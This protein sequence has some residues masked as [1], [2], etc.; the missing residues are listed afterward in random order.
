[1]AAAGSCPE[2][3]HQPG[4]GEVVEDT[5][6]PYFH[7][8]I[9]LSTGMASGIALT[10]LFPYMSYMVMDLCGGDIN[11]AGYVSGYVAS[12]FMVG[13]LF[14]SFYW[15]GVADQIGRKPVFYIASISVAIMSLLFGLSVNI[16]MAIVARLLLGLLNPSTGLIKTVVSELCVEE[17]QA[18]A[19]SV[20]SGSWSIGLV[21][22]PA[23][24]GYT[25][26]PADQYPGS[27]VGNVVIF[28]QFPYLLPNLI[29]AVVSF[30]S[31]ILIYLYLPET[32][33][34]PSSESGYEM[35][36]VKDKDNDEESE[37]INLERERLVSEG[38]MS[39]ESDDVDIDVGKCNGGDNLLSS[40]IDLLRI[41]SVRITN[42]AYMIISYTS[43]VHDEVLP[44]WALSEKEKGLL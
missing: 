23:I 4:G 5:P 8:S 10:G 24:G 14:S 31:L 16:Y 7:F 11:H 33:R 25:S 26:R 21:V 12:A 1:M 29:T 43:I 19:M 44:L 36:S 27:Y 39:D 41:E 38:S 34:K 28:K 30:I 35:V 13:R 40:F 22:G 32:L 20:V 9:L 17:H 2:P 3:G 18:F 6:F 15:G 42:I 37:N